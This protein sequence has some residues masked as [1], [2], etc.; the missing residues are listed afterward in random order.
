[1]KIHEG[2]NSPFK[3]G[4]C[5]KG[6]NDTL[7]LNAH[8]KVHTGE[9]VCDVC[10]KKFGKISDLYRHIKIHSGDRPYKCDLC[11]KTFCQKVNL[12]THQRTHTGQKAFR[13]DYCGLGFSRKTILQQHMKTHLE[14][15][16][17]FSVE[18]TA[19]RPG[20]GQVEINM[21]ADVIEH[22]EALSNEF[23]EDGETQTTDIQ[24]VVLEDG[25]EIIT[26]ATSQDIAAYKIQ[27]VETYTD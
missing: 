12:I 22:M 18:R 26:G 13:C 2:D 16:E 10:G 1:M 25:E 20:K 8:M 17:D 27:E 21:E 24:D 5:F 19:V 4:V 9:I 3:C 11:G 7:R 14:D 15:E 6:F 23:V